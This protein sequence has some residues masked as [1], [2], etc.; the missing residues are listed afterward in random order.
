MPLDSA[1]GQVF[2]PYCPSGCH[3]HWFWKKHQFL[4]LWNCFSQASIQKEQNGPSTQLIKPTSCI[5]RLNAKIG[6]EELSNF[7]S[8]QTLKVDIIGEVI[9]LQW[10]LLKS[11]H[12]WAPILV[13]MLSFLSFQYESCWTVTVKIVM[14]SWWDGL[15]LFMHLRW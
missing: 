5:E 1:I 2:T 9:K 3:G 6:A 8:S 4:A 12:S 15:Q 13:K 10:S 14:N 11:G 7:L